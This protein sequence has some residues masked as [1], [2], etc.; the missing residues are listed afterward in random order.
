M[1]SVRNATRFSNVSPVYRV[2]W[3]KAKARRDRCLEETRTL[4]REMDSVWLHF[5]NSASEWRERATKASQMEASKASRGMEVYAIAKE[6]MWLS[7]AADA[8]SQFQQVGVN[9]A[10]S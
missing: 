8:L 5:L 10:G 3:L 4:L 1:T 2:H 6:R 7:L 9:V